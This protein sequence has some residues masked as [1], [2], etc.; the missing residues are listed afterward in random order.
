MDLKYSINF[1]VAFNKS[2]HFYFYSYKKYHSLPGI[3]EKVHIQQSSRKLNLMNMLPAEFTFGVTSIYLIQFI[4]GQNCHDGCYKQTPKL[5]INYLRQSK[6]INA[7]KH[8]CYKSN[9]E[10]DRFNVFQATLR[11]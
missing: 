9:A 7:R 5:I 3:S 11:S 2:L 10:L 1:T 8:V 6:I 4:T